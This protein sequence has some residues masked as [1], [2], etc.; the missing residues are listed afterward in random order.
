MKPQTLRLYRRYPEG[1]LGR[2]LTALDYDCLVTGDVDVFKANGD[3]LLSVRRGAIRAESVEA[4]R[5]VLRMLKT[6][7]SMNRGMASGEQRGQRVRQSGY[8]SGTNEATPVASAIIG[9][10]DRNPRFPFCRQSAFN[11][12]HADRFA[13]LTPFL[14]DAAA[15]FATTV[16]DRYAAQMY[17]MA[18]VPRDFVI[19]GTPWTTLTVNHNWQTAVHHDR[20]DLKAGF[21]CLTVLRAGQYSGCH[22]VAPAYRIAVDLGSG[23]LLMFDPHEAHGNTAFENCSED[24]E[25]ISM[26]LY[27]RERM[28]QCGTPAEELERAKQ[29]GSLAGPEED[30]GADAEEA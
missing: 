24:F 27:M 20:G 17:Q 12:H 29:R 10:F 3:R 2:M 28:V 14:H 25:R 23:D 26:V 13:Q 9:H 16:P 7:R 15:C 6:T 8:V 18:R 1:R 19:T 21:S 5:P 4:A 30:N 22:L 11:A